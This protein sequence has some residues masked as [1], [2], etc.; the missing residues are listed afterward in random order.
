M[1]KK[2][3]LFLGYSEKETKLI[4]IIKKRGWLVIQKKSVLN[5]LNLT[6]YDLIL[7]FGYKHIIDEKIIKKLKKPI[8]NLHIGY[9]PYNKGSHPNL[10]SFLDQ[11]PSGVSIH[12]INSDIDS[13]PIIFRRI[14]EFNKNNLTFFHTY[15]K[16][17]NE[18]ENLFI[19]NI[20]KLINYKY[21]TVKQRKG[22]TIHFKKDLEILKK[23]KIFKGWKKNI[24][25]TVK[26]FDKY[27]KKV[28]KEKLSIIDEIEKT[29]T[30]NNINWM[31]LLRNSYNS[32]PKKTMKILKKINNDDNKI[33]GL[34]HKLT[35]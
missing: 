17:K 20:D 30:K 1:I 32:S 13:G 29:R 22:G 27:N 3:C 19:E 34:F 16:L 28:N 5:G 31:D 14:I 24:I 4:N 7:S 11:T 26:D 15:N 8:I 18:I 6:K 25:E 2:K 23:N 21:S 10:W 35:K 33:S 12:E 9:L